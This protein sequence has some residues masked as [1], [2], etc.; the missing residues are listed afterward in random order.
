MPGYYPKAEKQAREACA[1][2][3]M[4]GTLKTRM[5]HALTVY[6]NCGMG[7]MMHATSL[8]A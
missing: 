8:K 3:A 6:P 2:Q 4:S 5:P 7:G 1:L